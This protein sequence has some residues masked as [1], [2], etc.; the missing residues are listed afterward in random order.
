MTK[1]ADWVPAIRWEG[2]LKGANLAEVHSY[3]P[4]R[5]VEI[6]EGS[7]VLEMS[8]RNDALGGPVWER[9]AMKVERT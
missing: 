9:V 8:F 4:A 1:R 2:S 7:F 3:V 6:V 5:V